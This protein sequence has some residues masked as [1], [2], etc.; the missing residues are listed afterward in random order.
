MY[1]AEVAQNHIDRPLKD[2][3]FGW[4]GEAGYL[5]RAIVEHEEGGS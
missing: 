5:A 3:D 2:F 4:H 1:A